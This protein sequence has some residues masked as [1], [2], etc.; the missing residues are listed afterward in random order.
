MQ[1]THAYGCDVAFTVWLDGV[2][3][4][5]HL[6]KKLKCFDK[7]AAQRLRGEAPGS[8]EDLDNSRSGRVFS[9]K[10][11]QCEAQKVRH[12][13]AIE[14]LLAALNL[15]PIN[16]VGYRMDLCP[17]IGKCCIFRMMISKSR[18]HVKFSRT[19]LA[20]FYLALT[21]PLQ[22]LYGVAAELVIFKAQWIRRL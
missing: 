1:Q 21:K 11:L 12:G 3:V 14:E 22:C 8:H 13:V 5:G 6:K 18:I 10:S 9:K 17:K 2:D 20:F 16:P 7:S 4:L 15:L 19:C